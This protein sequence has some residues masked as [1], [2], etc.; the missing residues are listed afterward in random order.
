[1]PFNARRQAYLDAMDIDVWVAR[2]AGVI[3][4]AV[5]ASDPIPESRDQTVAPMVGVADVNATERLAPARAGTHAEKSG[6]WADGMPTGDDLPPLDA[7]HDA[8]ISDDEDFDFDLPMQSGVSQLGWDA[9]AEHVAACTR[10]ELHKTRTQTVF[11]VGDRKARLMIVG[12][13]PGRDEDLQGEPFVGRAGHLLNA[14]LQ[15]IG[16]QRDQVY[17][18][19]VLKCRPPNNRDPQAPEVAACTAYLWR[20][21]QLIQPTVLVALGRHAAHSLL[22]TSESLARLRGRAHSLR[23]FDLPVVVTYHPAYLLRTPV[24]KRKAWDDLRFV[25]QLLPR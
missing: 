6:D 11:G 2:D 20:Q 13:A 24:D 12:E 1:M 19:N 4:E 23:D 5:P 9:L 21:V 25:R 22:E 14:M 10:C 15:A 16:L 7:Y 17:I 18:A 8:P 3:V